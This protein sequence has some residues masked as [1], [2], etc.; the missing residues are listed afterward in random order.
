MFK[1]Q[2]KSKTC[3]KATYKLTIN[4]K[5][6]EQT[7]HFTENYVYTE[8]GGKKIIFLPEKGEQYIIDTEN[9]KLKELD[10]SAQMMQINQLKS[11]IGEISKEEK[12]ENNIRHISMQNNSENPAQLNVNLQAVKFV[13]LKNTMYQRFGEFQESTQMVGLNLKANEIIKLSETVFTINGQEQ[14][15]KLELVNI[16]N[17][18]DDISEIDAYYNYKIAK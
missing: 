16:E 10:I 3:I 14:K 15:T 12:T 11:M 6:I 8:A 5:Q 13:G 9:K 18:T 17:Y 4:N 7:H 1:K 2:T